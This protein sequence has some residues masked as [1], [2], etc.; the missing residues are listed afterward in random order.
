MA[1][2][3]YADL[4]LSCSLDDAIVMQWDGGEGYPDELDAFEEREKQKARRDSPKGIWIECD[5]CK[6][7]RLVANRKRKHTWFCHGPGN[8]TCYSPQEPW[9][10]EEY[11][12]DLVANEPR[13]T[14]ITTAQPDAD[15]AVQPDAAP[16]PPDAAPV[17]QQ[18]AA[19]AAQPD[20]APAVQEVADDAAQG[21]AQDD[22]E[23]PEILEY[24][25]VGELEGLE[26]DGLAGGDEARD[27]Q[28]APGPTAEHA[29]PTAT[30]TAESEERAPSPSLAPAAAAAAA[31]A[32]AEGEGWTGSARPSSIVVSSSSGSSEPAMPSP[33][34]SAD[35]TD[36][37]SSPVPVLTPHLPILKLLAWCEKIVFG[38]GAVV[39]GGALPRCEA[40][41]RVLFSEVKPTT[42]PLRERILA[43][44]QELKKLNDDP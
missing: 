7:W 30:R 36:G 21:A 19:P 17:A 32:S 6:R 1:A 9:D 43:S 26:E 22:A 4:V 29:A 40:L 34:G 27:A 41:E 12:W 14:P 5:A 31:A 24:D 11:D 33:S 20:T 3:G 44:A 42:I 10:P 16:A 39:A 38:P 13:K 18:D 37:A 15:P 2:G 23:E 25:G 8:L 28:L 35:T